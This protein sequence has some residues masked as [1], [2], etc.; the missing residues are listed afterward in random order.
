M[1]ICQGFPEIWTTLLSNQINVL[2]LCLINCEAVVVKSF[3][4]ANTRTFENNPVTTASNHN[5]NCLVNKRN[6]LF[7]V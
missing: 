5:A 7:W 2:Q 3:L 6:F 1:L 4:L